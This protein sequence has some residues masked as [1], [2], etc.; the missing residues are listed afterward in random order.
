MKYALL[1]P[2]VLLFAL[3][4]GWPLVELVA[5]SMQRTNFLSSAFVGF[6]NY[7]AVFTD[8][9]YV[10]AFANS[11]AYIVLITTLQVGAALSLALAT[12]GLRRRMVDVA[13]AVFYLP[14]LSAGIIIAQV[15]RW[16]FHID[17][18]VNWAL[19]QR[20]AWWSS[21]WTAIPAVSA[22][23]VAATLGGVFLVLTAAL[24]S[25]DRGLFDAARIDGAGPLAIKLRIAVPM[26]GHA[27]AAMA[28]LA[29]ISAPQVFETVYALAPYDHAATLTYHIY[30][31]AFVFGQHGRAAAGAVVL[32]VATG[33]LAYAQRRVVGE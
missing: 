13:R 9:R 7:R 2:V 22:I 16:A 31:E 3:M 24:H 21:A 10:Q 32:M 17:G 30:R 8:G 19:G 28:L 15:W 4:V 27:I 26:I 6:D 29:M 20:I 1:A 33:G 11:G 12:L 18:P 25:I 23:V 14:A 5:I